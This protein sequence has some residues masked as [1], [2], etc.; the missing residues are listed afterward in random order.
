M[1][2][3]K[4][5]PANLAQ[6]QGVSLAAGLK[7][8]FGIITAVVGGVS[9]LSTVTRGKLINIPGGS[10]HTIDRTVTVKQGMSFESVARTE[11]GNPLLGD[12]LRRAQPQKADLK[13]GDQIILVKKEEIVQIPV[14]PQSVALKDAPENRLLLE[15]Y[16]NLRGKPSALRV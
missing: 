7:A 14:T 2:L 8:A 12:V 10:L 11:Y 4:L 16:L 1:Q 3:K 9:G 5:D 6:S 13:P 15:G